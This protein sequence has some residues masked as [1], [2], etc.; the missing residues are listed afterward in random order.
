MMIDASVLLLM[1]IWLLA[2]MTE[3]TFGG[4]I[5]GLV[6]A[7]I[8]TWFWGFFRERRSVPSEPTVSKSI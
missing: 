6:L 3:N 4:A 8:L 2:M 5:H 7:A 1:L